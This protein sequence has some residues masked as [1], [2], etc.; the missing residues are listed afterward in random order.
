MRCCA[1]HHGIFYRLIVDVDD[2]S[3]DETQIA[4]NA[5]EIRTT[6]YLVSHIAEMAA[7]KADYGEKG[8]GAGS[9]SESATGVPPGGSSFF[10]GHLTVT[11][12]FA[13]FRVFCQ[14]VQ[15]LE[16]CSIACGWM[17]SEGT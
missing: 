15:P 12:D 7:K 3:K 2:H 17:A 16:D 9:S 4:L 1:L 8:D 5:G 14:A 13:G 11:V 10:N 6:R